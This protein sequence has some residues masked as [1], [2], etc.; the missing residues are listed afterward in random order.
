MQKC[1]AAVQLV[2]EWCDWPMSHA[3]PTC[4]KTTEMDSNVDISMTPD[5]TP[6]TVQQH[7]LLL[8]SCDQQVCTSVMVAN[9]CTFVM[10]VNTYTYVMVRFEL[11]VSVIIRRF[12]LVWVRWLWEDWRTHVMPC[13]SKQV[14]TLSTERFATTWTARDVNMSQLEG[15]RWCEWRVSARKLPRARRARWNAANRQQ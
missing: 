2:H 12:K 1:G 4:R 14:K 6:K 3:A 9:K 15:S 13:T 11:S 5:K 8:T 7:C 10:L